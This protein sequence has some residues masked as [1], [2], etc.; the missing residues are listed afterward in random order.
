MPTEKVKK[1]MNGLKKSEKLMKD[2][3]DAL[4]KVYEKGGLDNQTEYKE[5]VGEIAANLDARGRITGY[6]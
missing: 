6:G 1:A 3:N 5:V 4:K 2:L